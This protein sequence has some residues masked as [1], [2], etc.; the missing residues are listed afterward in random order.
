MDQS[1]SARSQSQNQKM[2]FGGQEELE[3]GYYHLLNCDIKS[4]EDTIRYKYLAKT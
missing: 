3:V 4:T 1:P 2:S